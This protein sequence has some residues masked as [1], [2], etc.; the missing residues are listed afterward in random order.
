MDLLNMLTGL[1]TSSSSVDAL[2]TKTGTDSGQAKSII[3]TALPMLLSALTDN[4]SSE[5]GASSLLGALSQHTNTASMAEQISTAD[6][7]DGGKIISH[8]LGDRKSSVLQQISEKTGADTEQVSKLLSNIAPGML[9]GISAVTAAAKKQNVKLKA[10]KADATKVAATTAAAAA[11]TEAAGKL[12]AAKLVATKADAAKKEAEKEAAKA[13]AAKAEA[14]KAEA[15]KEE[16]AG[17]DLSS[18]LGLLGGGDVKTEDSGSGSGLLGG[19]L[20]GLLGGGSDS[21]SGDGGLF[22]ALKNLF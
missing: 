2:S 8:I 3:S 16:S 20:S 18:L 5:G 14:A 13:E 12:A 4:A 9:S 6:T 21:D 15:E 11:A 17:L 22:G 7:E 1:M 10:A 19:L